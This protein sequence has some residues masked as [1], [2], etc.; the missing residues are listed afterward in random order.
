VGYLWNYQLER[1]E[2][3]LSNHVLRLQFLVDTKGLLPFFAGT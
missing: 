2:R 1:D 3:N